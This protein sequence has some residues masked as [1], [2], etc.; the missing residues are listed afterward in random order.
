MILESLNFDLGNSNSYG[1]T[2]GDFTMLQ[3]TDHSTAINSN[4]QL[5]KRLKK[6]NVNCIVVVERKDVIY[7]IPDVR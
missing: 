4:K 5:L 2:I 1:D 6:E 3:M 7:S